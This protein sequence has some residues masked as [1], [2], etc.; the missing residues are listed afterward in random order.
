MIQFHNS[1]EEEARFIDVYADKIV[2][3]CNKSD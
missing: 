1:L 2:F 3:L